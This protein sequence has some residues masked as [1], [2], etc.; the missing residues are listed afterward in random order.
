MLYCLWLPTKSSCASRC[1]SISV[2]PNLKYLVYL[3]QMDQN[4]IFGQKSTHLT[5]L[6]TIYDVFCLE[7]TSGH[8]KPA[9]IWD[10]LFYHKHSPPARGG[11]CSN[12]G[13]VPITASIFRVFVVTP[14]NLSYLY[15]F[16]SFHL[17]LNLNIKVVN[18]PSYS[19]TFIFLSKILNNRIE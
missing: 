10:S 18:S 8:N 16:S 14:R 11:K 7:L 4:L 15:I 2:N 19:I 3:D 12:G 5:K 9:D 13:I 6:H 17:A 1:L